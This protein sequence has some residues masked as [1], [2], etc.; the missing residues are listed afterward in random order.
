[1]RV[2]QMKIHE[3]EIGENSNTQVCLI[4]LVPP[5]ALHLA[6]FS[7]FESGLIRF[8]PRPCVPQE[9]GAS[10]RLARELRKF[11]VACAMLFSQGGDVYETLSHATWRGQV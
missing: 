3:E 7:A 6:P 1:M 4:L 5:S 11:A 8:T 2:K 10:S 9:G